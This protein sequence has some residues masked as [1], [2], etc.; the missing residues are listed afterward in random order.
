MSPPMPVVPTRSTPA[1]RRSRCGS[2]ES[3]TGLLANPYLEGRSSDRPFCWSMSAPAS[4]GGLRQLVLAGVVDVGAAHV[5][6]GAQ[7]VEDRF[8]LALG[9]IEGGGEFHVV[10]VR[11]GIVHGGRT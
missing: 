7:F 5:E 9:G 1:S 11:G 8:E 4:A 2:S 10:R 6:F 3:Y